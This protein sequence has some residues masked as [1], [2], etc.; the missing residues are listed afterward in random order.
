[1][2]GR[3]GIKG[4]HNKDNFLR[5]VVRIGAKTTGSTPNSQM[6]GVEQ[7]C[8]KMPKKDTTGKPTGSYKAQIF[9]K[10][11]Y[12]PAKISTD[13]YLERGLQAANDTASKSETGRLGHEWSGTDKKGVRWHGYCDSNGN[14]TS[15]YPED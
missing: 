9:K 13:Q 4:A 5:E 8:Y 14:I 1:M 6:D 12:D 15:F 11:V 10:T 7:I 3:N 2:S